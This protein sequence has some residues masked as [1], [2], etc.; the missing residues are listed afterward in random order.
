MG[1]NVKQFL[2]T[3]LMQK[4]KLS[5]QYQ[6]R[7]S[8]SKHRQRFTCELMVQGYDYIGIGNSTN[9]KDAQSNAADDFINYLFRLKEISEIELSSISRPSRNVNSTQ[10]ADNSY[11]I[12]PHKPQSS[13]SIDSSD[14]HSTNFN[15]EK[16]DLPTSYLIALENKKNVEANEE[17]DLTAAIHGNWTMDNAKSRL[18][19]FFQKNHIKADYQYST[20]GPDHNR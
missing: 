15:S 12:T 11:P 10:A 7:A 3:W 14:N 1:E 16:V 5:P 20:L 9:K 8:G 13:K 6:Y 18:N 2:H 4:K 17:V 19:E